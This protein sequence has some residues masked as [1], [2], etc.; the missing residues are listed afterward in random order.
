MYES[1]SKNNELENEMTL[2]MSYFLY[3]DEHVDKVA[4]M[5]HQNNK[6]EQH[7]TENKNGFLTD[8]RMLHLDRDFHHF[9]VQR[10]CLMP[11]EL[12][13]VINTQRISVSRTLN[14]WKSKNL[15][16]LWFSESLFLQSS[17]IGCER[18]CLTIGHM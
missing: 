8:S 2:D 13:T 15:A 11:Q 16:N 6:L 17:G 7:R 18:Q 10:S 12:P 5:S 9:C 4:N 1:I 3:S 14:T